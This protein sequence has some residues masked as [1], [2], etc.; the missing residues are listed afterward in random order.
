[1]IYSS[2]DSSKWTCVK[3]VVSRSYGLSIGSDAGEA[4]ERGFTLKWRYDPSEQSLLVQC[5]KKPIFVTCGMVTKRLTDGFG[6]CG[7]AAPDQV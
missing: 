6:D 2:V 5:T 7:I 1:V 3:D 4:S